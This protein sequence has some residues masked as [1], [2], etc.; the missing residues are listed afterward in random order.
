MTLNE[1]R[2]ELQK[3]D[4]IEREYLYGI[5]DAI[6]GE[7]NDLAQYLFSGLREYREHFKL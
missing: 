1:E 6:A 7:D 3:A 2:E 5:K 4:E